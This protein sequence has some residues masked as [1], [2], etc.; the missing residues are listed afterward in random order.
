VFGSRAG[1]DE[2]PD[3]Y[4][5]LLARPDTTIEIGD[6]TVSVHAR[7]LPAEERDPIW[8]QHKKEFPNFAEYEAKTSRTI[9]V[10]LL[11]RVG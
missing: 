2:T 6:R 8:E 9:P 4:L 11:E 1:A 3:W 7:D 10:V 5:N